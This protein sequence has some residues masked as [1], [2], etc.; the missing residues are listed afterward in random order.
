MDDVTEEKALAERLRGIFL[1]SSLQAI[2]RPWAKGDPHERLARDLMRN[3][4]GLVSKNRSLTR[5]W[6]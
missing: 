5:S 6:G 1:A 3:G 2:S 4:I